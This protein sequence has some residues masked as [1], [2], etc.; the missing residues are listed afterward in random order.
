MNRKILYSIPWLLLYSRLAIAILFTLM[1]WRTDW[2][3]NHQNLVLGLFCFGFIGDIFDGIIAR[4]L[5]MDTTKL[6]RLDSL[7]DMFFWVASTYLLY[8]GHSTLQQTLL[9]GGGIVLGI[10]AIE[11]IVC[12]SKFGKGPSSHNTISKFFGLSLFA[13][14]VLGFLG[15]DARKFGVGVFV[16]GAIARLDALL[17]YVLL[18]EW[19]HDIPSFRHALKLNNGE[20]LNKNRLFH[21]EHVK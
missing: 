6:R 16:F 17:I 3:F 19:T 13:F 15:I 1:W 18:K 10:I 20:K 12:F 2:Y 14:F 5:K 4:A 11:Y 8:I 7:F 9:V 21:S